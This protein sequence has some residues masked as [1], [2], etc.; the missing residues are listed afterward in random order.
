MSFWERE[1][2][3]LKRGKVN[4]LFVDDDEDDDVNAVR[5]P[6][7]VPTKRTTGLAEVRRPAP[8]H[9]AQRTS[10]LTSPV[11]LN[12]AWVLNPGVRKRVAKDDI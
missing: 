12:A 3:E 7:Y 8:R 4:P 10:C 11:S 1:I 5:Q 6:D 2:A 9:G